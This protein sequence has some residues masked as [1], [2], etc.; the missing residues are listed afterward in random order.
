MEQSSIF[1][2]DS[3]TAN[4]SGFYTTALPTW[5]SQCEENSAAGI[6]LLFVFNLFYGG[7]KLLGPKATK[8]SH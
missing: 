8:C 4:A 2:P 6:A 3:Q 7:K 1:I 5:K